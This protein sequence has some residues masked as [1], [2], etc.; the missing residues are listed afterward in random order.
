MTPCLEAVYALPQ[1]SGRTGE[2]EPAEAAL[3]H[4]AYRQP[5]ELERT[6]EV[7]AYRLV[8]YLGILLPHEP[9]VGRADAV[10]HD[11]QPNRPQSSLGLGNGQGA[12]LGRA[13]VGRDVFEAN[14]RQFRR[15]ARHDHHARSGCRQQ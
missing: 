2:Y 7:D 9:L 8:P 5:R 6:V 15:T 1:R 3:A 10:V 14:G 13:E 4:T 12:A 11:Q